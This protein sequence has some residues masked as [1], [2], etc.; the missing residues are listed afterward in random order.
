MNLVAPSLPFLRPD[1]RV[2]VVGGAASQIVQ[3]LASN[4]LGGL[5]EGRLISLG[6]VDEFCLDCTIANAH[7]LL[8]P[9]QYGGGSNV[10]TAEALL[11]RRP[12]LATPTA[13]RGFDAFRGAPGLRW[14]KD[15]CHFGT[16]MLETLDQPAPAPCGDYAALKSILW[17]STVSPLVVLLREVEEEINADARCRC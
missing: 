1:Q 5:A 6:E 4:K 12:V 7:V 8:L 17:E 14:V 15:E 11:S 10:K 2:V 9:I 3:A 13:M 16:A